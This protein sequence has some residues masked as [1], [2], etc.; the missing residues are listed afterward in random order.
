MMDLVE[1]LFW[2]PSVVDLLL[3]AFTY[4]SCRRGGPKWYFDAMDAHQEAASSSAGGTRDKKKNDDAIQQK[5]SA[6][7]AEDGPRVQQV[8]QLAMAAYSAYACTFPW[9]VYRCAV[10]PELRVGFCAA[11]TVLMVLKL[12]NV[13]TMGVGALRES[14]N[15]SLLLFNLPTYGGYVLAKMLM[16]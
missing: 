8:W 9:A 1:L 10:A 2:I 11:M 6:A 14:K 3:L 5:T 4:T 7:A 15:L 16:K 13:S 12:E